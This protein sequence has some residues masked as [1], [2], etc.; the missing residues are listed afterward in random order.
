MN[1]YTTTLVTKLTVEK[2]LTESTA[3]QYVRC[4]TIANCKQPFSSL[5]FLKKT[6]QVDECLEPYKLNT[7]KSILTAIVS[8]LKLMKQDKLYQTYLVKLMGMEQSVPNVKSDTQNENWMDWKEVE[9]LRT[10]LHAKLGSWESRLKYMV[11]CLYTQIQPRRNMDYLLMNVVRSHTKDLPKTN[12]YL[13]L[14]DGTFVFNTYKTA[15]HYGQ[16]VI[17]IPTDLQETIVDYL[18]H[19]PLKTQDN[20]ALLVNASGKRFETSGAMTQMLNSIF[21]KKVGASMLRH[22]YLSNK[23]DLKE[24]KE[25][26]ENM[27]HSLNQQRDYILV[28]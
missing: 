20:Y 21:H 27:G 25:D 3:K 11:L 19:H 17:A 26:A 15:K 8:V 10:S 12:N 9:A 1:D 22:I 7:Q 4:L 18:V 5:G 28:E 24:M 23:Y 16:Q 14:D 13:S 6:K 2:E